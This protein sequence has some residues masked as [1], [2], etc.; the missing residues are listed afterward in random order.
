MCVV[1]NAAQ[2]ILICLAGKMAVGRWPGQQAS[3]DSMFL[4]IGSRGLAAVSCDTDKETNSPSPL[5]VGTATRKEHAYVL[6]LD[7]SRLGRGTC[8]PNRDCCC[9]I[10]ALNRACC[11]STVALNV[12]YCL[13]LA[14]LCPS[15]TV[16]QDVEYPPAYPRAI[17][18][19][20]V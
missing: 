3:Q 18:P 10:V 7:F 2:P 16:P 8:Q 5:P 19:A 11:C 17:K 13:A 6:L 1:K 9:S 4:A 14:W 12:A 20:F 15:M